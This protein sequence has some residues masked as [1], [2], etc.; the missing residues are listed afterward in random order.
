[1][2]SAIT[3]FHE[4]ATARFAGLLAAQ[5]FDSIVRCAIGALHQEVRIENA[6]HFRGNVLR[7]FPDKPGN[8]LVA[9]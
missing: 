1:L 4:S 2:R 5:L 3:S 7:A 6:R 9:S 8:P